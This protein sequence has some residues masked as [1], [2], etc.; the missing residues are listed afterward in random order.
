M[1]NLARLAVACE[2]IHNPNM[3]KSR[4]DKESVGKVTA[5]V[6]SKQI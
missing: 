1:I 2:T 3:S 4:I 6:S 5:D